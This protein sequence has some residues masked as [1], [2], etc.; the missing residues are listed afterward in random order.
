M[1]KAENPQNKTPAQGYK[2]R[3]EAASQEILKKG[4][5]V[6]RER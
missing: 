6:D 3:G 4:V 2:T 5:S 1:I